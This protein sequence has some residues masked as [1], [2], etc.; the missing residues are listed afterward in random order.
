MPTNKMKITE[1]NALNNETI[2]RDATE[3]EI[4]QFKLDAEEAALVELKVKSDFDA[5]ASA[6]ESAIAKLEA[7]GLNLEEAQAIFG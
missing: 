3:D 1:T 5:K 4:N 6:K 7:L 2:E